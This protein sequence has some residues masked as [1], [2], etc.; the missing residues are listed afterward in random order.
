MAGST[1][2]ITPASIMRSREFY[3]GV[4]DGA[5]RAVFNGKLIVHADAQGTDAQQS[6]RNLLLSDRAEVDTKPQL[7]IYADDVKCSHGATVGQLDAEQIGY[8][9]S[10]GLDEASARALLTFAF[11]E[12]VALRV[13]CAPLKARLEQLLRGALPPQMR[14]RVRELQ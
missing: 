1:W 5:A 3:K 7:E 13:S 11:A 2:I 6:N 10:R 4:L 8:L 9:R 14:D 12:D